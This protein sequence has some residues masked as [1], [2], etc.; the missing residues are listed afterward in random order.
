MTD[1]EKKCGCNKKECC[2]PDTSTDDC[3]KDCDDKECDKE[4]DDKE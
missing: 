2:S 3:V 1:T 4:C